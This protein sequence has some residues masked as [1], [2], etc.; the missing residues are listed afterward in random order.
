MD[1]EVLSA[2]LPS[3]YYNVAEHIPQSSLVG[4]TLE[5]RLQTQIDAGLGSAVGL[6]RSA[7]I[8][9][10]VTIGSGDLHR[11]SAFRG[12]QPDR[13]DLVKL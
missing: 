6:M 4:P 11:L 5:W 1:L 13:T 9:V 3:A 2:E 7:L 12:P 10:K 8:A